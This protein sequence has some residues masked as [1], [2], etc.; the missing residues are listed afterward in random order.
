MKQKRAIDLEFVDYSIL[1]QG[2]LWQEKKCFMAS[3]IIVDR[4][5]PFMEG[6]R[7]S[8]VFSKHADLMARLYDCATLQPLSMIAPQFSFYQDTQAFKNKTNKMNCCS[9]ARLLVLIAYWG[10]IFGY[11]DIARKCNFL[12]G[13][14]TVCPASLVFSSH[15][16][17]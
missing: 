3:T 2:Y 4:G 11:A 1:R 9:I 8:H 13:T 5:F 15:N 7:F 14:L 10:T 17:H 6:Y 12:K 16:H